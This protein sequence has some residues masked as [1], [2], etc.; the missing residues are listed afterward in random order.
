MVG[1]PSLPSADGS[2]SSKIIFTTPG[3]TP[4]G[5]VLG[6]LKNAASDLASMATGGLV[7]ADQFLDPV[8]VQKAK[9]HFYHNVPD[10]TDI[11]TLTPKPTI[12]FQFN[13]TKIGF[14][15]GARWNPTTQPNL[16]VGGVQVFAGAQPAS[17]T[18]EVVLDGTKD[19]DDSVAGKVEVLLGACVPT[20]EATDTNKPRPP[21]VKLEWGSLSTIGFVVTNVRGEFTLFRPDGV[22]LRAHC[23]ITLSEYS[24]VAG[25][26]N[27]TSIG[28]AQHGH[29]L[30]E[31]ETLPMLAS[32][33]YDDPNLWRGIAEA[34]GIDDPMRVAPGTLLLV[35]K[36]GAIGRG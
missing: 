17:L 16:P 33:F 15:K 26:Q 2:A 12:E 7:N 4:G 32:A 5:A 21:V 8:T 18:L 23:S 6:L 28:S 31:G 22:P 35:P 3:S 19:M 29:V 30:V 10:G 20:G 11:A 9:L 36:A 25:A 13:P 24:S 34:N 1:L 27:P 14:D